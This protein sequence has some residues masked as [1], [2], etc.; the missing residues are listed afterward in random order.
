MGQTQST[1]LDPAKLARKGKKI[2]AKGAPPPP[3]SPDSAAPLEVP[4]KRIMPARNDSGVAVVVLKPTATTAAPPSEPTTNT[5]SASPKAASKPVTFHTGVPGMSPIVVAELPPMPPIPADG[6]VPLYLGG[7]TESD[8]PAVVSPVDSVIGLV[9]TKSRRLVRK[10][11]APLRSISRHRQ[12]TGSARADDSIPAKPVENLATPSAAAAAAAEA[13]DGDASISYPTNVRQLLHVEWDADLG[14]FRGVPS[15]W[16][17][18]FPSWTNQDDSMLE[19]LASPDPHMFPQAEDEDDEEEEG[20]DDLDPRRLTPLGLFTSASTPSLLPSWPVP[21]HKGHRK[22]GSWTKRSST[23]SSRSSRV[24]PVPSSIRTRRSMDTHATA[25][26]ADD[27]GSTKHTRLPSLS[28]LFH[29]R[30]KS[31]GSSKLRDR[32]ARAPTPSFAGVAPPVLLP[33]T[34]S[35][36]NLAAKH[37]Q[38]SPAKPAAAGTGRKS[39]DSNDL[40]SPPAV[41]AVPA[42]PEVLNDEA[43]ESPV[44]TLARHRV[45]SPATP[46]SAPP[47]ATQAL[48][49][50][51]VPEP[52]AAPSEPAAKSAPPAVVVPVIHPLLAELIQNAERQARDPAQTA[53]I[54]TGAVPPNDAM[55]ARRLTRL[56]RTSVS[57]PTLAAMLEA[58]R[59]ASAAPLTLADVVD[60]GPCSPADA[61]TDMRPWAEG[62]R[63]TVHRATHAAVHTRVAVKVIPRAECCDD[64]QRI[65]QEIQWMQRARHAALVEFVAAHLVNDNIWIVSEWMDAGTLADVLLADTPAPVTRAVVRGILAPIAA[66]LAYLHDTLRV[67]HRD[68]R[69]DHILLTRAGTAKLAYWGAAGALDPATRTARDVRG[70]AYWMAPEVAAAVASP[71]TPHPTASGPAADVWALGITLVELTHAGA[72]PHADLGEDEAVAAIARARKPPALEPAA[73]DLLGEDGVA[74]YRACVRVDPA[75]RPAA[76]ELGGLPFLAGCEEHGCSAV[77]DWVAATTGEA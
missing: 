18:A 14:S 6:D 39:I 23:S 25:P 48:A 59:A 38:W 45:P 55:R 71:D 76:R 75:Q 41:P 26:A 62:N 52:A 67:V 21:R 66:A 56:Q 50:V 47:A 43:L 40:R 58:G 57:L 29:R 11:S 8:D 33:R 9:R 7:V 20:D 51:T 65:V 70:T 5:A 42:I 12:R 16:R 31:S 63:G 60:S 24:P 32:D 1:A 37:A 13:E 49:V 30:G 17:P 27:D 44:A 28:S 64:E 73:A 15:V 10:A 22:T 69:S 36:P 34:L 35:A 3:A 72:Y 77:R 61:Y 19:G 4:P 2:K 53:A 54:G 68:V 74:W 46:A